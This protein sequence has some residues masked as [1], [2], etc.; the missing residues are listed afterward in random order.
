[1]V[2]GWSIKNCRNHPFQ[3]YMVCVLITLPNK[4]KDLP[5]YKRY[6]NLLHPLR[7]KH[8]QRLVLSQQKHATEHYEQRHRRARHSVT[9]IANPPVEMADRSV[10]VDKGHTAMNNNDGNYCVDFDYIGPQ[11][12]ILDST[13]I[14]RSQSLHRGPVNKVRLVKL[15][16]RQRN[17]RSQ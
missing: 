5:E 14:R 2:T 11:Q 1:M 9:K 17:S 10:M 13:N 6:K 3:T 12:P 16:N 15:S 4:V 8:A 7:K